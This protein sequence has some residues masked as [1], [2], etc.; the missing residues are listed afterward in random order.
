M[1]WTTSA[2][3]SAQSPAPATGGLYQT[4]QADRGHVLFERMCARCHGSDLGGNEPSEVP[5]LTG[6][7]FQMHWADGTVGDVFDKIVNT[8][9]ADMPRSLGQADAV[10]I[11]AYV[12]Q[13]NRYA[14]GPDALLASPADRARRI[15][16][17]R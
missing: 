13:Q 14:A 7:T 2:L 12:L 10:E 15:E 6:D 5:A 17:L 4:T 16:R 3:I 9:P 8:M 11:L 1:L